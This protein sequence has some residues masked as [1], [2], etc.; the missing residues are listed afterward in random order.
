[1]S[2]PGRL[3]PP[4]GSG[5]GQYVGPPVEPCE[6]SPLLLALT[7]AHALL[8]QNSCRGEIAESDRREVVGLLETELRLLADGALEASRDEGNCPE[9]VRTIQHKE[10]R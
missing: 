8:I 9:E 6:P 2:D 7:C 4:H 3:V 5:G 10:G 1:M